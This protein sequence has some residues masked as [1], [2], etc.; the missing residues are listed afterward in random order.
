MNINL[1]P[2]LEDYHYTIDRIT[3][4]DPPSPVLLQILHGTWHPPQLL[5]NGGAYD[6]RLPRQPGRKPGRSSK[7]FL[8]HF[9][10]IA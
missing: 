5:P 8:L 6:L 1:V 2:G 10:A 9:L 3:Y 4:A 7:C